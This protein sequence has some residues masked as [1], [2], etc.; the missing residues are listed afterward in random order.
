MTPRKC[1]SPRRANSTQI[2]RLVPCCPRCKSHLSSRP[3]RRYFFTVYVPS[4][5]PAARFS[6][7]RRTPSQPRSSIRCVP[8]LPISSRCFSLPNSLQI[9]RTSK[10][11]LSIFR[12]QHWQHLLQRRYNIIHNS[13]RLRYVAQFYGLHYLLYLIFGLRQAIFHKD[14]FHQKIRSRAQRKR[15]SE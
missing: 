13:L 12:R 4:R 1:F 3:V 8:C 11:C 14:F 10:H 6:P 7:H 15:I 2:L 5:L 9:E